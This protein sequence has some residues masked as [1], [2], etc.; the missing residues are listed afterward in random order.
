MRLKLRVNGRWQLGQSEIF[1]TIYRTS[2]PVTGEMLEDVLRSEGFDARLLG[3]R[4]AALLGAGQSI[5]ELRIEVPASQA[6][7]AAA[8]IEAVLSEVEGEEDDEDVLDAP[9]DEDAEPEEGP[10]IDRPDGAARDHYQPPRRLESGGRKRREPERRPPRNPK[11]RAL[12]G[13]LPVVMPGLGQIYGGRPWAGLLLMLGVITAFGAGAATGD[14][15]V[16]GVGYLLALLA[17]V[18][19]GQLA[20]SAH[21]EGRRTGAGQQVGLGLLE[22]ALVGGLAVAVIR[23][24]GE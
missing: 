15:A 9:A 21:N 20:V 12:A 1:E 10:S 5:F 2:D 17:D 7:D 23:S 13:G 11:K 16:F 19:A 18:I 6:A 14:F 24:V 4:N 22:L 8:T 3:T